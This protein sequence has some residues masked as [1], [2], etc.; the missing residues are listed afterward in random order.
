MTRLSVEAMPAFRAR[1]ATFPFSDGFQLL[2]VADR[3]FHS[4]RVGRQSRNPA[5]A[6]VR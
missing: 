6:P 3:P 1:T 4:E 2:D 5:V